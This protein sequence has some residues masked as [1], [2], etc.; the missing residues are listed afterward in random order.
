MTKEDGAHAEE[1][2]LAGP[3]TYVSTVSVYFTHVIQRIESYILLTKRER[4]A[5][6][7]Q[8]HATCMQSLAS[9]NENI[10]HPSLHRDQ[11]FELLLDAT[12]RVRT[13]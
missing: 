9:T 4:T 13:L 6:S 2:L 5:A 12:H 3:E 7:S 8:A 10:Y 11:T 1:V